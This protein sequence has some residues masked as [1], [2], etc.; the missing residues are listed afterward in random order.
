MKEV[1]MI[2]K[3]LPERLEYKGQTLQLTARSENV[4]FCTKLYQ[5]DPVEFVVGLI[6]KIDKTPEG[7]I[8]DKEYLK[9]YDSFGTKILFEHKDRK[10]ALKQYHKLVREHG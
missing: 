8:T 7:S 4:V 2:T 5:D 9:E 10:S 6:F 1:L 3:K